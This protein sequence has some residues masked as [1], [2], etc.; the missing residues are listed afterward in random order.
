MSFACE[1]V[2]SS[3]FLAMHSTDEPVR[4]ACKNYFIERAHSEIF[5]SL[6][7]VGWCDDV[8]WSYSRE[9]QDAYFPFMDQLH[10]DLNIHRLRY[11]DEDLRCAIEAQTLRRLDLFNRLLVAMVVR[12]G[13]V[14][15]TVNEELLVQDGIP[16]KQYTSD[17]EPRWSPQKR[18][19]MV[20]SKPANGTAVWD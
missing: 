18:P 7:H 2:D 20:G 8:I 10:T 13:G 14:L 11:E 4:I 17:K 3:F 5:M 19:Y 9:K 16:V 6:E 1:F 12:R 15:Y